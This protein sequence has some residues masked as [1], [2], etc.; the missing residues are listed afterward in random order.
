VTHY[1]SSNSGK[2]RRIAM[3]AAAM[4]ASAAAIYPAGADVPPMSAT[5]NAGSIDKMLAD[6]QKA[7]KDGNGRAALIMFKNVV[8]LAP[9]NG[10]ARTQ[11]GIALMRIGDV[12]GAEREL[13]QARKDGAPELVVLPPLFEVMLL[14]GEN[15]VLLDQFPDPALDGSRPAA[16]DIFKARALAFQNLNKKADASAAMD[17]SLAARRD[18][19]GLLVRARLAYQQGD[20]LAAMKFV[21]E[22]IAKSNGPEPMLSKV[23][24]LLASDK[25]AEALAL[26]NQLLAKYPGNQQAR[27]ARVEAY[28]DLK[29]DA[30]AK[31]EVD[32]L[33]AKSPN[34]SLGV[35]YR[36]L[37]LARAG[38][39]KRA[40]NFAQNLPP[41]F[42]E[43]SPRVAMMIAQIAVDAGNAETGASILNHLLVKVPDFLFARLRLAAVQMSQNNP[44]AALATLQPV[45]DSTNP[46]ALEILSNAYLRLGRNAEALKEFKNLDAVT[47]GRADIKRNIGIL[48]IRT[49]LVDQGIKDLSAAAAK[50]PADLTV[51]DPLINGLVQ[52]R[53]FA[54]ALAVSDRLGNDPSRKIEALLYRGSVLSAQNDDAGADAAFNKA[55]NSD[56]KSV[57]ALYARAMMRARSQRLADAVRDLQAIVAVDGKNVPALLQLARIAQQQGDDRS[58]RTLLNQAIAAAP[59]NPAPRFSLIGY[60]SSQKKYAE[61]QTAIGE[62][63]RVQP[64]SAEGLVVLGRT[65]L[66]QKQN[67]EA[68]ATYRRLASL[69]PT[70]AGPQILLGSALSI[71]QDRAGAARALETAARLSPTSAEVK[72]AQ[73]NLQF[74]QGNMDGAV[75]LARAFQTANPG[76]PADLLLAGTLNRAHHRNDAVVVL[77]KS[78]S[79]RP[80]AAVLLQ[81]AGFMTQANDA[82]GAGNLMSGWLAKNPN[83]LAVRLQYATFLMQQQSNPQAITQFQAVLKQDPN[84]VVA[85]NDLGWLLQTSDPKRALSLLTLAQK[86]APNSP[87]IAD[88][89]GWAKLQQKDIAGGLALLT[90]AHAAKPQDGAITYHLVVALDAS[91][92][93]NP[94]RQMLKTLLASKVKFQDL[95]A[96]NK[97]AADW[98]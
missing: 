11:L 13:R 1:Q 47:K 46:V 17:H 16:A 73:I 74:D 97:L 88:T 5:Q 28:I 90:Q 25:N 72:S 38:D 56:P 81:L 14:R 40:W 22:A 23:G 82:A 55:V 86:L 7:M 96:A 33:L 68:I 52:Q 27:F 36:A 48:E 75:A 8:S 70:A 61:A 20:V 4:L 24:M 63:L 79:D 43:T 45:K 41:E 34:A 10:Y 19:N 84:N 9:R 65:Q 49:G 12:G 77:K 6:A 58:V 26:A 37:L 42:R 32:S 64:N 30:E 83:D 66:A 15:Q 76:S 85:L 53:R 67:K 80:S 57:K 78:L 59:G 60:L 29:R 39:S 95:P 92:Q 94:A 54:E 89:L 71:S 35:Y 31:A 44:E 21:D 98:H 93:R 2:T 91:G 87:D 50:S 18:W 62:L 51:A 3:L 69:N